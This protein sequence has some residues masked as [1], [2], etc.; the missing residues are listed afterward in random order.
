MLTENH[1][2]HMKKNQGGGGLPTPRLALNKKKALA[3]RER[4]K[5]G[6]HAS[7]KVW[8]KK[9]NPCMEQGEGVGTKRTTT[10]PYF[11]SGRRKRVNASNKERGKGTLK[12]RNERGVRWGKMR[13]LTEGE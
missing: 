3:E 12:L 9:K 6:T 4:G 8:E 13:C 5:R 2:K 11:Y 10:T 7:H 1:Q